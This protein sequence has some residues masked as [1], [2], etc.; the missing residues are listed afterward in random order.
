MNIIE[1][2]FKGI[3]QSFNNNVSNTLFDT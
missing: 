3:K 1:V 2:N